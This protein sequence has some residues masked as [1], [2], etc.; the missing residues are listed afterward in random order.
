MCG[1]DNCEYAAK[2][3]GRRMAIVSLGEYFGFLIAP[4]IIGFLVWYYFFA[5]AYWLQRIAVE[6]YI[7]IKL[8]W[9]A[10][11]LI[12]ILGFV[13]ILAHKHI[14]FKYESEC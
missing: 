4:F 10:L 14:I 1:E 3:D 6:S 8:S 9:I 7:S 13:A 5:S 11:G 12:M 2:M